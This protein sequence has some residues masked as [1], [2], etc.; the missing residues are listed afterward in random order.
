MIQPDLISVNSFTLFIDHFIP[1]INEHE[2]TNRQ[3]DKRSCKIGENE[4]NIK[5]D[6]YNESDIMRRIIM[7]RI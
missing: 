4:S 7:S 5:Q 2:L 1:F 3:T 6:G